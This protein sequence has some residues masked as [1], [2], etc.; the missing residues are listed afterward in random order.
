MT[1]KQVL[2]AV[3]Q[4]RHE[5]HLSQA[6]G[7]EQSVAGYLLLLKRLVY[8]AETAWIHQPPPPNTVLDEIL[9]MVALGMGCL[10]KYG[11]QGNPAPT[12]DVT[13]EP[14]H[15]ERRQEL[16]MAS[17]ANPGKAN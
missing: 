14:V 9:M 2:D 8:R 4:A 13:E 1:H 10:E 11:V 5:L 16:L 6:E 15:D 7:K 17:L 3:E 12:D